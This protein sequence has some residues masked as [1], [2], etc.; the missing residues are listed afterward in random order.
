MRAP[1]VQDKIGYRIANVLLAPD[2][3]TALGHTIFAEGGW[4]F[5][6][7]QRSVVLGAGSR[8]S[9]PHP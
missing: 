3:K 5:T 7:V 6:L 8:C 1:F 4:L 2:G 9:A